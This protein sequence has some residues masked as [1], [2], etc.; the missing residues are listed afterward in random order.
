MGI[1][2]CNAIVIGDL[3]N[4]TTNTA[5]EQERYIATR[6]F[7]NMTENEAF[8]K[9]N[10]IRT[11]K[12]GE[13][14]KIGVD[15]IVEGFPVGAKVDGSGNREFTEQEFGEEFRKWK[16]FSSEKI[17]NQGVFSFESYYNSLVRDEASIQAWRDCV[18]AEI[19]DDN[20]GLLAF[21]SRDEAD[22]VVLQIEWEIPLLL[23]ANKP[24]LKIKTPDGIRIKDFTQRS[25]IRITAE[26]IFLLDLTGITD[27]Q[28]SKG[29]I[30]G[31]T[32][33]IIDKD[34]KNGAE[35]I[36]SF[37]ANAVIPPAKIPSGFINTVSVPT[38]LRTLRIQSD[39][40]NLQGHEVNG[41]LTNEIVLF[42]HGDNPPSHALWRIQPFGDPSLSLFT[43]RILKDNRHLQG[44][45]VNGGLTNEIVLFDHGDN[46]PSH[47]IWRIQPFGD[48]SLSL[49][50]LRILEHNQHLQGHKV[51]GV[52][53][54][55]ILFFDHGDNPPSHA[56]WEIE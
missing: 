29:F 53:T 42:D 46:P 18:I 45:K 10:T 41:G 3:F 48:P 33:D 15:F 56:L 32:V 2:R 17:N 44:H 13:A 25:Q 31:V 50:T 22:N 7:F 43:L 1:E 12:S 16:T 55:K 51:N 8:K 27:E 23:A 21:G 5:S 4:K 19:K 24:F 34:D 52:L 20:G 37:S 30:I 49:F 26:E 39:G 54:D 11:K 47:A 14:L 28:K 40:R 9:Y 38:G 36:K 35:I 6:E